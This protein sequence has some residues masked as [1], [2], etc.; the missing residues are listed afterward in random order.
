MKQHL[1]PHIA[2]FDDGIIR[3]HGTVEHEK[4]DYKVQYHLH[5]PPRKILVA[6]DASESL[7]NALEEAL[8]ELARQTQKHV[9]KISGRESWKRKQRRKRLKHFRSGVQALPCGSRTE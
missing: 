7:N 1:N 6:K 2:H 8:K 9:A 4:N 5:L 3:L